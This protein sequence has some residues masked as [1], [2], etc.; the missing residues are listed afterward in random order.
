MA[1][2]RKRNMKCLW[3]SFSIYWQNRWKK[4][5]ENSDEMKWHWH[6]GESNAFDMCTRKI[7]PML[8]FLIAHFNS[9]KKKAAVLIHPIF[10]HKMMNMKRNRCI[11]EHL[12]RSF[13]VGMW[14]THSCN[15]RMRT[16]VYAN[17]L[18]FC[19]LFEQTLR[20]T[21]LWNSERQWELDFTSTERITD[22]F[23]QFPWDKFNLRRLHLI[24]I[25]DSCAARKHLK[26]T[27]SFYLPICC[28]ASE[29]TY[30]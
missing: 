17:G 21:S 13:F 7:Q 26:R 29:I 28:Q 23:W 2:K 25:M 18:W 12:R 20:Y 22:A 1:K 14:Q 11:L 16:R 6:K 30:K 24:C 4:N 3:L 5:Q 15:M 19:L 27:D 8:K 10:P 9:I